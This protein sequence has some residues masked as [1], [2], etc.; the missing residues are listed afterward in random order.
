MHWLHLLRKPVQGPL[1][2]LHVRDVTLAYFYE[3][4]YEASRP[5]ADFMGYTAPPTRVTA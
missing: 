1:A 5:Y 3:G 4:T 2:H